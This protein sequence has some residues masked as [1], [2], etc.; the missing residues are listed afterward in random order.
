MKKITL[1]IASLIIIIGIILFFLYKEPKV[2]VLCYHNVSTMEEKMNFPEEK[3]WIID[4]QN[5][6]EHLKYLK[7]H[8][9]KTLTTKELID[10]KN[11]EVDLP[12]KSVMLTFDDGFLSNYKYAFPLLKKYEMNAV[13]FVIGNYMLQDDKKEWDGNVK[14]YMNLDIM[15]KAKKEYPNIEFA[16]HSLNLHYHN[17]VNEKNKEEMEKD[18]KGFNAQIINTNVYAYPFGAY[19][20]NMIKSLKDAGYEMA[21]IY[22][23]TK[24]EYRKVSRKDDIYKMPRLNMSYGMDIFKFGLRLMMPF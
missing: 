10:W 3:D 23:P 24:K 7:E 18:L 22:G 21:F 20:D 17:S 14:K 16:S 12:N 8:N 4:V 9:Y 6:E 13:V 15:E 1:I 2:S 11:G 5:F 19:N